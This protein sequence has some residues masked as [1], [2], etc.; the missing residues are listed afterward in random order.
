MAQPLVIE[1]D[2]GQ[3]AE[4]EPYDEARTEWLS[5]QGFKVLRF[6]N[7]DVLRDT[8]AVLETIR[9]ALSETLSPN[10]SPA[11]GRGEQSAL[12]PVPSPAS[13]RGE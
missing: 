8:E 10:P 7:D 11:S 1:L 9:L 13:G 2:G 3:H 4:R 5:S 6:W 12:S